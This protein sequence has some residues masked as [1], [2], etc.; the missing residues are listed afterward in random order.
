LQF[1]EQEFDAWLD[2]WLSKRTLEGKLIASQ[3]E[4]LQALYEMKYILDSKIRC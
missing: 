4:A 3:D 2:F 1:A